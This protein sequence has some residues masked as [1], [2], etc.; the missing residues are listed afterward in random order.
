[1]KTQFFQL[2]CCQIQL[3]FS[4]KCVMCTRYNKMFSNSTLSFF[5]FLNRIRIEKRDNKHMI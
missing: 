1:M 3:H 2:I 4:E 5:T